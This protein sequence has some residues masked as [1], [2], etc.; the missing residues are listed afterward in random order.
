MEIYQMTATQIVNMLQKKEVS[1]VDVVSGYIERIKQV[2]K[3]IG[4][5]ITLCEKEALRSAQQF[6]NNKTKDDKLNVLSGLPIGIKDNIS[7]E[8]IL[9][10][11]GS[12]ML[13]NY[14]PAFDATVIKKIKEHGGIVLGK[15][16]MDEFAMGS[17]NETSY[18]GTVKNPRDLE[19]VPGGSSGGSAASVTALEVPL[20]LGSDTGGSIRQP[21]SFCG[22][23]GFK[24]TY[25]TVSR[26]GLIAFA[27]SLDQIGP[28]S[29][30][31]DDTALLYSVISGHDSLDATSEDIKPYKID[32]QN[33]NLDYL[34]GK[35]IAIVDEYMGEEIYD[36]GK[37][38]VRE[39]AAELEKYGVNIIEMSIPS[40][41]YGLPAY[42][43]I[44][45]AEASSNLARFDG[46]SY[47]FR[48]KDCDNLDELYF[49]S[50]TQG[51]GL[52][53]KRRIMLGTFVLSS[54]YFDA[55]Y[56]R[57]KALQNQIIQQIDDCF[58]KCDFV[59]TPTTPTSAFKIGS[60]ISD[61]HKMH[62][63]DLCT[64]SANI[65][66]FPAINIPFIE[67]GGLPIGIQLFANRFHDGE[68]LKAAK[69]LESL[70]G[71]IPFEDI[72]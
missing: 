58:K 37:D 43:V 61:P 62:A 24:P 19:Y 51:F 22:I 55:Y 69:A 33:V 16:N 30:T 48:A 40:T 39:I 18:F 57:A 41:I 32:L 49:E 4:A 9:T 7:T 59:L 52:E 1:S 64:V 42:Y 65:A 60:E 70:R 68:L 5:F 53:V 28:L 50:R 26:Y 17:S 44:S 2:D 63:N 38:K 71:D 34:K 14:I 46:V 56:K 47:G 36:R 67:K 45:S 27:S 8:G 20:S 66:G 10:T 29:K 13:Y 11:C 6:D 54:G 25:G 72:A 12:K 35:T 21:A 3:K 31:V 15:L 23:V